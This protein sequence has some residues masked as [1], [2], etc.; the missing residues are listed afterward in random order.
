VHL[1]MR[2]AP[3]VLDADERRPL[4]LLETGLGASVGA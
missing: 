1:E 4:R 3:K 2:V